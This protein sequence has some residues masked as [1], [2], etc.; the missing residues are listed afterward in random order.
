[1]NLISSVTGPGA[2]TTLKQYLSTLPNNPR[3]AEYSDPIEMEIRAVSRAPIRRSDLNPHG[4][5]AG[6]RKYRQALKTMRRVFD[7]EVMK[8]EKLPTPSNQLSKKQRRNRLGYSPA[9]RQRSSSARGRKFV[10]MIV[11]SMRRNARFNPEVS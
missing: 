7:G 11:F 8:G 3:E 5:V 10:V 4:G 6:T 9:P 2:H 1:M